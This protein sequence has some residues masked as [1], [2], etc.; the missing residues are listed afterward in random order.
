M[1][2][3]LVDVATFPGD[4]RHAWRTDGA[5]GLWTEL[6]E[7][8]IFRVARSALYNLYERDLATI[9]HVAPPDGVEIRMLGAHEHALLGAIMTRRR[10]AQLARDLASRTIFAALRDGVVVG[11]SWWTPYFDS[12]LSFAP[13]E[14]P[15]DAT[16]HGYVHVERAERKRG[17]AS[18]LFSAGERHLHA[19]G[20][21]VCWFLIKS[22][23]VA[24]ARTARGRWGGRSRHIAEVSYRKTLFR[25]KRRL[26]LAPSQ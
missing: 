16:F 4:A 22:T 6:A 26:T 19:Q 14:L 10:L 12:A 3:Y 21:R 2:K 13:L 15:R 7:R 11:Y 23:N 20:A 5:R 25:T 1:N 24:G 17:T 18:A 9:R 8:T